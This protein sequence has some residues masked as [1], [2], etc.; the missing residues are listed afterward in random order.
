MSQIHPRPI[1]CPLCDCAFDGWLVLAG[2]PSGPL[3]SELR[4]FPEDEDPLPKQI[5]ACPG[6]GYTGEVSAF[7]EMAPKADRE[8]HAAQT[9]AWFSQEDWEDANDPMIADRPRPEN[10]TLAEQ[11]AEHLAVRAG[12]ACEDPALRYEHHAQVERWLG[13][14]PLRE[15]DGFLRAAWMHEDAKRPEEAL[16]CRRRALACYR[17]GVDERKW[18]ARREDLVVIAYLVGELHRKLGEVDEG[19]RWFEQAIAWSSGLQKMQELV[20]LAERQALDPRDV[21]G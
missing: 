8:V 11:L 17:K 16:R 6:C 1:T 2:R 14:G 19:K 4:R 12:E 15:A 5:N 10:S 3:S 21:V 9:G 7:E 20:E 13:H 18:F